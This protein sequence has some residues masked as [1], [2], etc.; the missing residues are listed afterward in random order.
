[1]PRDRYVTSD[2][3]VELVDGRARGI[4]GAAD[5]APAKKSGLRTV[6]ESTPSVGQRQQ[7]RVENILCV[8]AY[9][10][11]ITMSKTLLDRGVHTSW[12]SVRETLQTHQACTIVLPPNRGLELRIRRAST[13]PRS[14]KSTIGLQCHARQCSPSTSSQPQSWAPNV[15]TRKY[16]T[17]KNT[18]LRTLDCGSRA[19]GR[20]SVT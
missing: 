9:H 18:A 19:N 17:P 11:L 5:C 4:G 8:L 13:P 2:D 15:V 6:A 16:A 14:A 7:G 3:K 10:W 12:E 1:M 20:V